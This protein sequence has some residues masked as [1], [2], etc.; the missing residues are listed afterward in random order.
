MRACDAA[1][2]GRAA[3]PRRGRRHDVK[4]AADGP[5]NLHNLCGLRTIVTGRR[6]QQAN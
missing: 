4:C 1:L 2:P 3:R 6:V 5:T